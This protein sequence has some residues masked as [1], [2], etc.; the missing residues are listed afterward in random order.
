MKSATLS[1]EIIANFN[2]FKQNLKV[3]NERYLELENHI[4]LY[5]IISRRK[6]EGYADPYRQ[7]KENYKDKGDV[8]IELITKN[9][10][11]WIL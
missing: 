1:P 6:I 7:A 4:G 8:Y 3:V 2:T 10:I 9:N 5:V 11:A